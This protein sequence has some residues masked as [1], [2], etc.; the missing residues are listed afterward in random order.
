MQVTIQNNKYDLEF[1]KQGITVNGELI[2]AEISELSKNTYQ[3]LLNNQ[4]MIIKVLAHDSTKK[5]YEV[6][7]NGKKASASFKDPMDVLLAKLGIDSSQGTKM[8]N[9]KAPMPGLILEIKVKEGDQVNKGDQLLVLEAMKMENVIKSVG[10]GVIKK[11]VVKKGD[12]V[13]KGQIL[14]EF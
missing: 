11:V 7:F 5:E 4:S 1:D 8:K 9:L 10:E 12:S 3:V 6:K 14:L 2:P 13:D